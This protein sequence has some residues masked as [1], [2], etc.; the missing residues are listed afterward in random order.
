MLVKSRDK[1]KPINSFKR[2]L[3]L[4]EKA[5]R[6]IIFLPQTSS[7]KNLFKENKIL[8]I[9]DYINYKHALFVRNSLRKENLPIFNNLFTSLGINHTHNTCAATNHLLDIYRKQTTHYGTY[10]MTRTASVTWINMLRNKPNFVDCKITEFKRTIFQTY[11]AK[12]SNNN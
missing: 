8:K 5:I 4:Q 9:S 6:I 7:S 1:T 10:S 11:L 12:Y 3:L 2:L